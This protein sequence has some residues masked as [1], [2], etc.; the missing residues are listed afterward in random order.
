LKKYAFFILLA[1]S[2]IGYAATATYD[3]TANVTSRERWGA[4]PD[5]P[6]LDTSYLWSRKNG[7]GI[8]THELLSL[9]FEQ[10]ATVDYTYPWNF[11]AQT[12]LNNN[13]GQ[14]VGVTSRLY[15]N[16]GS[17]G[18]GLHA[19][20]ISSGSGDTIGTNVEMSPKTGS[21]GRIIAFNAQARDGYGTNHPHIWSEVA[22][23][24]QSDT[25]AGFKEGVKVDD[26]AQLLYGFRIKPTADVIYGFFNESPNTDVALSTGPAPIALRMYANSKIC[27]E[28]SNAVCMSY[29]STDG[30]IIFKIGAQSLGY[31][32]TAVANNKCLNC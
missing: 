29:S 18:V 30:R 9:I 26:N 6:P 32:D 12:T 24:I 27:F 28:S 15:N 10:S 25:T 5:L 11:Y 2:A 17:W 4:Q 7:D 16:A 21:T 1:M 14:G 23:N 31:I 22:Y 3:S 13:S 20:G 19:E 8:G